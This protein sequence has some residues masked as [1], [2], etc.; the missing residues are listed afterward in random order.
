MPDDTDPSRPA[1]TIGGKTPKIRI[2]GE[3]APD[4]LIPDL[5]HFSGS[6]AQSSANGPAPPVQPFP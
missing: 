4:G 6:D 5:L 2:P 1:L 3:K